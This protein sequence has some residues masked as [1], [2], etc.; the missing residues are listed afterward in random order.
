MEMRGLGL[1]RLPMLL[2]LLLATL[3]TA[4]LALLT[5]LA[6]VAQAA[7]AP[8]VLAQPGPALWPLPLSV[9]MTPNLLRLA[10][11]NFYISHSPNSTAG[12]SCTLLEEAFRRYH[13]Y[14]FGFYKFHHEPAEFQARTQLQQLLVSITL[15]SECDA[16]PNVSSD[17]SC[18]LVIRLSPEMLTPL[19]EPF[20]LPAANYP[21]SIWMEVVVEGDKPA[22][23]EIINLQA[24]SV[25]AVAKST[26][27]TPFKAAAPFTALNLCT[28]CGFTMSVVGSTLDLSKRLND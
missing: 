20:C 18:Y 28:L 24:F 8:G 26:A 12:P 11:E 27:V 14:I 5:Q 13:D 19:T 2:A 9:K 22:Q 23:Y 6:L 3:L 25:F 16:F 17:E 21:V 4:M 1:L 7:R 15:Q 10:P